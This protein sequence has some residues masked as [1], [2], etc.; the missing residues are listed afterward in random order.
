[1]HNSDKY[2]VLQETT[3]QVSPTRPNHGREEVLPRRQQIQG[4]GYCPLF[5]LFS[6]PDS[7]NSLSLDQDILHQGRVVTSGVKYQG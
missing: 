4:Y 5:D 2:Y 3:A 7:S 6:F 1:V